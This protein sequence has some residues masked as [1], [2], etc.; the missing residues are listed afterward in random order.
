MKNFLTLLAV[1]GI[2]VGSADIAFAKSANSADGKAVGQGVKGDKGSSANAPGK[3][4]ETG[5][6]HA[7]GQNKD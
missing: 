6:E 7:P 4:G 2:T 3:T 1:I 5:K